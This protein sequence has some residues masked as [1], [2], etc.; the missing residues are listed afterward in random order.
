MQTIGRNGVLALLGISG[1]NREI[2]MPGA[3]INLELVLGNGIIFGSVNANR[4]YF[5]MGVEHF[6]IFERKW[7]GAMQKL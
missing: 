6:G 2:T 4:R 1:G 7:P 3:Q 5:E